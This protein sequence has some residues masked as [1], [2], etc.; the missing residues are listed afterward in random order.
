ME[1]ME[2][3]HMKIT[4]GLACRREWREW[5]EMASY[6]YTYTICKIEYLHEVAISEDT[7][8]TLSLITA[9]RVGRRVEIREKCRYDNW[10]NLHFI[11]AKN[12]PNFLK[13]NFLN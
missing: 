10:I 1:G 8:T 7:L 4:A 12:K 3:P 9:G 11:M 6:K 5:K 13:N 2:T